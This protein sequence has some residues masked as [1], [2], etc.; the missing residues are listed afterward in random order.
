MGVP[1]DERVAMGN[2][3]AGE[4]YCNS[5]ITGSKGLRVNATPDME[6]RRRVSSGNNGSPRRSRLQTPHPPGRNHYRGGFIVPVR[7]A[8]EWDY[9]NTN[10]VDPRSRGTSEFSGVALSRDRT[11]SNYFDV[12]YGARDGG[13]AIE[14]C[15][16]RAL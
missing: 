6:E 8:V 5:G 1:H 7:R 15:T 10:A 16:H 3:A 12:G 13:R 14:I 4:K 11:R 2:N 9:E